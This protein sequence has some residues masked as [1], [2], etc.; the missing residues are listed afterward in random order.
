VESDEKAV[1]IESAEEG[2]YVAYAPLLPGCV[3]QGET[4]KEV[5]EMI[6]DAI[7]G[8]ISVLVEEGEVACLK[9]N[10]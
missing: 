1:I 5:K 2:G 10:S 3:T 7:S 4:I 8:Y 6:S 9:K